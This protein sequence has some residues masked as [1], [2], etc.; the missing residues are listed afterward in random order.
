VE[1]SAGEV[2]ATVGEHDCGW[3]GAAPKSKWRDCQRRV[4]QQRR[5]V[6]GYDSDRE[7]LSAVPW[8]ASRPWT[9]GSSRVISAELL[10]SDIQLH[11]KVFYK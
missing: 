3:G 4:S 2:M 1:V 8:Q 6:Q 5:W 10:F 9:P 7:S 11:A